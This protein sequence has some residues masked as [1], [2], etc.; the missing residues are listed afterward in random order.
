MVVDKY[1]SARRF[2]GTTKPAGMPQEDQD[3]V[4][5][6]ELYENFYWNVPDAYKLV[7]R[8]EDVGPIYLP[9]ARSMIEATWRF[10]AKDW[11]YMVDVR[12]GTAGD[13]QTLEAY[14]RN[15]FKRER[16]YTKFGS[17]KRWLLTRG[18]AM[19]H[20]TANPNKPQGQR[21]SI[22]ELNAAQYFP[23]EDEDDPDKI[24]GCHIV[25]EVE[26]PDDD[27][28]TV[29]RRQTYRKVEEL[30]GNVTI[31]SELALYELGKW[32]DRT[33]PDE[34][35]LKRI[36]VPAAP[37][38]PAITQIPV[39]HIRNFAGIDRF[40]SSQIRGIETVFAA[41]SQAVS[42]QDLALAMQGLGVYWTDS[43][44]PKNS[45]GEDAPFVMGPGEVV[46]VAPGTNFGR[47]SGISGSLPGIEHINYILGAAHEA[48]GVPDVA[49]GRADVTVAESGI[50]LFI[51]MSPLLAQNGEKESE[52]LGVMDNMFYDLTEMWLPAYEGIPAG[53]GVEVTNVVG[54]PMPR[55]REAEIAEVVQ[56]YEANLI[57]A[58]MAQGKLA[59]LGYEY[60]EGAAQE[61]EQ[62]AANAAL[63]ADPFAER[64]NKENT[65]EEVFP[66]E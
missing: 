31:T 28:K 38:P 22:H 51:Q 54:D 35:V 66:A 45:D 34:V 65:G 7:A 56:L 59:E 4:Q 30:N 33:K 25:D 37:L 41:A 42:D 17:Q 36:L 44:P 10:L 20:I 50:S 14:F 61:L 52:L 58:E 21:I 5:A 43:G 47:V 49:L 8:S 26:D 18:D 23:I 55:N 6:Y 53:T 15:M 24:V 27:T 39:Y 11:R 13:Q 57:T 40:G 29:S 63:A 62:A 48:V 9:S 16:M 32:D 60:P 19:W 64:M 1:A 12:T 2:F 3:R 46:E